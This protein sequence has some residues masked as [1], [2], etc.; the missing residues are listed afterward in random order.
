MTFFVVSRR[1]RTGIT[2]N[3]IFHGTGVVCKFCG[4]I[5]EAVGDDREESDALHPC[6]HCCHRRSSKLGTPKIINHCDSD[7]RRHAMHWMT[8]P[9]TTMAAVAAALDNGG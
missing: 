5:I 8:V 4:K 3:M 7:G 1:P 2:R 6:A 9:W